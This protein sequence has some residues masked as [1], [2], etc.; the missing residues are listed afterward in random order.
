MRTH[1]KYILLIISI[2]LFLISLTQYAFYIGTNCNTKNIGTPVESSYA[3]FCGWLSIGMEDGASIS[4]IAN[5]ILF[6]SWI[7]FALSKR[8]SFIFSSLA[9][10][11][12]ISFLFFK[13]V[14]TNE[15]GIPMEVS[16]YGIGYFF[17][18]S[19]CI[20]IM[21]GSVKLIWNQKR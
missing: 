2:S 3:L 19:S 16:H 15:A 9:T 1:L 4:W 12:A 11:F 17:W 10:L 7:T 8:I 5:P 14:I 13:N 20:V 18:L 6:L 21:I